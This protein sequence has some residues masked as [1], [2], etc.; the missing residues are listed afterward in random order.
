M[1]QSMKDTDKDVNKLFQSLKRVK[2][3]I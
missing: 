3:W 2:K 1:N